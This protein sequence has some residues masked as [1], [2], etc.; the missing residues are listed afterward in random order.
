MG[1]VLVLAKPL[2]DRKAAAVP[3]SHSRGGCAY[4]AVT[5]ASALQIQVSV[6][7]HL[8]CRGTLTE[9][10]AVGTDNMV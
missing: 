2:E 9:I 8:L 10:H 4:R 1:S 3:T 5:S 7:V 6:A